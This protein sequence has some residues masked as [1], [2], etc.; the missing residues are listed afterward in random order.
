[1]SVHVLTNVLVS[2]YIYSIYSIYSVVH[3]SN[4]RTGNTGNTRHQRGLVLLL[5]Q[6]VWSVSRV[7]Q[8]PVSAMPSYMPAAFMLYTPETYYTSHQD[9]R[10]APS[11]D[12][13]DLCG[14]FGRE[15]A[16]VS[17]SPTQL[18]MSWE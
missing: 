18:A 17:P 4:T 3:T 14:E 5:L 8:P 2:Y 1:M 11:T 16:V 10:Q 13:N 15:F 7:W 9:P 12:Q 6:P